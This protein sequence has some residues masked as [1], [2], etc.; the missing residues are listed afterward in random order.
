MANVGVILAAGKNVRLEGV[1]EPY[2]KPL[3]INPDG[4]ENIVSVMKMLQQICQKII[5]VCSKSN[6]DKISKILH[7]NGNG[8][9]S[10]QYVTQIDF[11]FPEVTGALHQALRYT[12]D[13]DNVICVMADNYYKDHKEIL[14]YKDLKRNA[15]GAQIINRPQS[16]RYTRVNNQVVFVNRRDKYD[17]NLEIEDDHN[18]AVWLG[19]LCVIP[20]EYNEAYIECKMNGDDDDIANVFNKMSKFAGYKSTAEDFGEKVFFENGKYRVR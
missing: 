19:P 4:E 18:D 14:K 6:I 11:M 15:V 16:L 12:Y 17:H 7:N 2:E 20:G 13:D 10:L 1:V 3:V 8:P 5:V 9:N